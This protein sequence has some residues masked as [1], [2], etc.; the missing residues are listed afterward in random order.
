MRCG[1]PRFTAVKNAQIKW[2]GHSVYQRVVF[3][4]FISFIFRFV[5]HLKLIVVGI[6]TSYSI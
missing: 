2:L 3:K 6:S 4:A 5:I 1:K